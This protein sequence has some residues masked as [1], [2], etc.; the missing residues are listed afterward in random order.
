M[1]ELIIEELVGV[2]GKGRVCLLGVG[3]YLEYV[4]LPSPSLTTWGD[5]CYSGCIELQ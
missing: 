2:S 3:D 1:L 5:F 4:Y